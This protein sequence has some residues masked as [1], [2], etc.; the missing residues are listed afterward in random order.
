MIIIIQFV[1]FKYEYIFRQNDYFIII[2]Q[3]VS[4]ETIAIIAVNPDS[5]VIRELQFVNFY[6]IYFENH[7]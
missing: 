6:P 7:T 3:I 4:M 2:C 1:W 5:S